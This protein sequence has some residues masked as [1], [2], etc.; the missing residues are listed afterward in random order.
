MIAFARYFFVIALC[1]ALQ[2][3]LFPFFL[4]DP[5]QPNLLLIVVSFLGLRS[6]SPLAGGAVFLTGAAHDC[7]SGIYFGLHSF[8][9]LC[10]YF[11][12]S[13]IS[14]QLYT[15]RRSLMILVVFCGT[16]GSGLLSLLLLALFSTAD[17][18]YAS[19]LPAIIPQGLV[20]AL[21][22]SVVFS[23]PALSVMEDPA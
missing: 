9:Y 15:N 8:T 13:H 1:L 18:I 7:F 4:D 23:F 3:A 6:C 21:V 10:L 14:G 12:L 17:G 11:I 5:Y 22:A 16:I 20:N 19:M 2:V